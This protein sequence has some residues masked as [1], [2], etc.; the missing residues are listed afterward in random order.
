[1]PK[2]KKE[3]ELNKQEV[4]K[5]ET[6]KQEKPIKEK[7]EKINREQELENQFAEK[8]DQVL[9]IAAEYDNFRKRSQR[10]KAEI[11]KATKC[12]IVGELLPVID[13]FERAAQDETESLKDYKKG[14]DMIHNQFMDIIEKLSIESY[15]ERGDAFDPNIH[16]AVMHIEDEKLGENVIAQVLSKGYRIGDKVIRLATVTVAN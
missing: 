16:N 9:R 12:D 1:M 6:A 3:D 8:C 10:E 15:G 4:P 5:Q 13:N 14:I 2:N 7:K 11:F